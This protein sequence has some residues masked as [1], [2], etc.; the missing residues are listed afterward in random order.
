[1]SPGEQRQRERVVLDALTPAARAALAVILG[2]LGLSPDGPW[3]GLLLVRRLFEQLAWRQLTTRAEAR[4]LTRGP[5]E[6]SA[7]QQLRRDL[8][9]LQSRGP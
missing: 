2:E 1:M 4:G 7:A 9:T 6:A 8:R 3:Y 5:A